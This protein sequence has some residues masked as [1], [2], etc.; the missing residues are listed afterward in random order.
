MGDVA[1]VGN[2]RRLAFEGSPTLSDPM[3]SAS[4]NTNSKSA[5][6]L[7]AKQERFHWG[8]HQESSGRISH[9]T[10]Q[11]VNALP[12]PTFLACALECSLRRKSASDR[13]SRGTTGGGI[14]SPRTG[15]GEQDPVVR[16]STCPAGAP[17]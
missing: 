15:T 9:A 13:A 5:P 7:A 14:N 17:N 11:L 3:T 2:S 8:V 16:Q 1:A 4:G 6:R 12:R 10:D